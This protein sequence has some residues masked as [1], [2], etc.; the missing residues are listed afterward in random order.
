VKQVSCILQ[1]H[2]IDYTVVLV[3]LLHNLPFSGNPGD[4]VQCVG[5]NRRRMNITSDIVRPRSQQCTIVDVESWDEFFPPRN[6]QEI[7]N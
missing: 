4:F 5:A 2:V 7:H 3:H 6:F 1:N